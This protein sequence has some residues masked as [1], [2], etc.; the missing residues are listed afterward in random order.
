MSS[1]A[2]CVRVAGEARHSASP[3]AHG[4]RDVNT[5]FDTVIG[6]VPVV[7]DAFDVPLLR[8]HMEKRGLPCSGPVIEGGGCA[9]EP[10]AGHGVLPETITG[11][12]NDPKRAP[13]S[14]SR[15]SRAT[16]DT[17]DRPDVAVGAQE[18]VQQ[19]G[20]QAREYGEKAQDAVWQLKAFVEKSLCSRGGRSGDRVH[21]LS[22][23]ER[24]YV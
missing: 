7:G 1:S 18:H 9:L 3:R 4:A 15:T 19:I 2:S 21:L 24:Y 11:E 14:T 10:Q 16:D 17:I 8:R 6:S 22:A 20:Q 12:S 5:I 23:L 13:G